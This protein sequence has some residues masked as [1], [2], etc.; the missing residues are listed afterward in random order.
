MDLAIGADRRGYDAFMLPETWVYDITVVLA[1]AAVKTQSITLGTCILG[2]WNRSAAT[3]AMAARTLA[4]MSDAVQLSST[5]TS[6]GGTI[7]TYMVPSPTLPMLLPL[8]QIGVP[9]PIVDNLNSF[10][11]PIVNDGYSSLTPNA[12][13]YFSQGVLQGLPPLPNLF[14]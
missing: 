12:G 11:E 7:T 8:Q 6:L 14:W 5:T 2:V 1:E 10:L 3:I 13:P 4:S 9:Q